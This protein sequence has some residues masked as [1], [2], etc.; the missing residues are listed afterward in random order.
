M[1]VAPKDVTIEDF[2]KWFPHTLEKMSAPGSIEELTR[3]EDSYVPIITFKYC[4]IHIDLAFVTL[5]VPSVPMNFDLKDNNLLRGLEERA[6]RIVNGPKVT[7]EIL[8]LVPQPKTFRT[9]LRAIKL[10][11]NRMSLAEILH[12]VQSQG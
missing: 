2:F 5:L 1:I 7:D 12:P 4:G 6:I 3:V 11:A 8:E 9:A 10:W